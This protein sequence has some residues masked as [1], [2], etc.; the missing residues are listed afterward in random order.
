MIDDTDVVWFCREL[1][2][3]AFEFPKEIPIYDLRCKGFV[4]R[5]CNGKIM[6]LAFYLN[7]KEAF[8]TL[9]TDYGIFGETQYI[10]QRAYF[11]RGGSRLCIVL[12]ENKMRPCIID[13]GTSIDL[14][15]LNPYRN[16]I[17]RLSPK[18]QRKMIALK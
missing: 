15:T 11:G 5:R 16:D 18:A 14:E 13:I 12:K 1:K 10:V 6:D 7:G 3:I 2:G 8:C 17:D 9:S 4:S